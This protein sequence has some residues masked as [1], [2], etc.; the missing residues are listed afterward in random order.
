MPQLRRPSS[1]IRQPTVGSSSAPGGMGLQEVIH[2]VKG[3]VVREKVILN[4]ATTVL[5]DRTVI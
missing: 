5:R 2:H 4:L 3:R 1:I